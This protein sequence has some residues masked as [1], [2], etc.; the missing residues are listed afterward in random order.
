MLS[1]Q[2]G[3]IWM[4]GPCRECTCVGEEKYSHCS[5]CRNKIC[6][7]VNLRNTTIGTTYYEFTRGPCCPTMEPAACFHQNKIYRVGELWELNS[8]TSMKCVKDPATNLTFIQKLT[9]MCNEK[10]PIV[11]YRFRFNFR[12]FYYHFPRRVSSIRSRRT[13][14]AE[15][16]CKKVAFSV[17]SPKRLNK[18]GRRQ[19][20]ALITFAPASRDNIKCY[21]AKRFVHRSTTVPGRFVKDVVAHTAIR[22]NYSFGKPNRRIAMATVYRQLLNCTIMVR[23]VC[24]EYLVFL[25]FIIRLYAS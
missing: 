18:R 24:W 5:Q 9:E 25:F 14:A 15:I 17:I 20:D 3:K 23:F 2:P 8:C 16:A 1:S 10:C 6:A 19:T 4:D 12:H 21:R 7:K 22:P 13:A 11:S